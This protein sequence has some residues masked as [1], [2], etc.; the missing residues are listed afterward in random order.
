M[1]CVCNNSVIL[2]GDDI[3]EGLAETMKI[4]CFMVTVF[5][6]LSLEWG[7]S[8]LPM[9]MCEGAQIGQNLRPSV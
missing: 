3:D 8:S 2:L 5:I 6:E 9:G 7:L 4:L 1:G